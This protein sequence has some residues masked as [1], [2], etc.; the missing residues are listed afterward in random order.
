MSWQL[1]G[2]WILIRIPICTRIRIHHLES[3]SRSRRAKMTHKKKI[4]RNFMFRTAGCSLLRAERNGW[5]AI[6][7]KKIFYFFFSCTFFPIGHQNPGS[8]WIRIR[9]VIQTKMLDPD[10]INTD[11]KHCVKDLEKKKKISLWTF[12]AHAKHKAE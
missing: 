7:I 12:N 8:G 6:S 2:I 1:I 3:G 11:L 5:I 9:I 4:L 10:Q